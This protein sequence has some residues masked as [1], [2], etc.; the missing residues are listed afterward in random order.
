M[1]SQQSGIVEVGQDVAV[2]DQEV[3]GQVVE[4]LQHR[5]YRAQRN[6]LACITDRDTQSNDQNLWMCFGKGEP[7]RRMI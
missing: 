4:D 7:S 5:P 6:V 1:L 3:F 2:H